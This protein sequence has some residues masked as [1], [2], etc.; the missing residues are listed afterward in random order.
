[1]EEVSLSLEEAAAAAASYCVPVILT[2]R[3]PF[4]PQSAT[5]LQPADW[6][7][8][9]FYIRCDKGGPLYLC[10]WLAAASAAAGWPLMRS[11]D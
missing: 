7:S 9:G 2:H 3:S 4:A 11:V 8:S 1:M 10:V 5:L 6:A